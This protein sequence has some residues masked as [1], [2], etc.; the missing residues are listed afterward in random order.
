MK[1][2]WVT[3][4][5]VL[6]LVLHLSAHVSV[7]ETG[8]AGSISDAGKP[9]QGLVSLEQLRDASCA[10]L[11]THKEPGDSKSSKDKKGDLEKHVKDC[12]GP[13]R[14]SEVTGKYEFRDLVPGWYVLRLRWVMNQPPDSK[15]PIG[16]VI[17][18]WS[19][20]YFP[21]KESGKYKGFAQSPPFELQ[22]D[23]LKSMEFNYDGEFKIQPD[24]P[25][26]LTW[27]KR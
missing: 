23:Q 10:D 26:P 12:R 19:I 27:L 14:N 5:L 8:L 2:W 20:S 7:Q 11:Y 21:G 6:V 13:V 9:V 22:P 25:H 1:K 4:W 17:Q 16:C 18:G 15:K 3:G 24:C